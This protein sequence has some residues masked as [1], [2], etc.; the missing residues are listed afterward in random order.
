ML[1]NIYC[2]NIKRNE[3]KEFVESP[4]QYYLAP[5]FFDIQVNGYN[6]ISL[7][8]GVT[9]EKLEQMAESMILHG[10]SRFIPTLISSSSKMMEDSLNATRDFMNLYKGVIPGL[11]IEGP[12]IDQA[13][14][15]IHME[16]KI[17]FFTTE[18]LRIVLEY[19]DYIA[20]MTISP[21]AI[22]ETMMKI[23]INSGIKLSLGHSNINYNEAKRAM[24]HGINMATH[25]Y[26]GMSHMQNARDPMAAEAILNSKI[27]AS[28]IGDGIHVSYPVVEM[29]HDI[30]GDK[31]ILTTDALSAAGVENSSDYTT[32]RFA[33]KTVYNDKIHGCTDEKGILAGSRL[34]MAEGVRNLVNKCNFTVEEAIYAATLAPMKAFNIEEINDYIVLDKDLKVVEVLNHNAEQN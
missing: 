29:I 11:H 8:E 21:T 23:L 13:K 1:K 34:T 22:D 9:T 14:K 5:A 18:D 28:V 30:L 7:D 6:R 16:S 4:E 17:R 3:L 10:V 24:D 33:G 12:F 2:E 25:L 26:N 20:Y 19:K 31:F 15:G 27:Y 32:F